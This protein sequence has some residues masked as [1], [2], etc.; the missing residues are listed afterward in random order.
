MNLTDEQLKQV[1]EYASYFFSP[2]EI[3]IILGIDHKTTL[4]IEGSEF[5]NA[6]QKGSLLSQ[7]KVRKSI[8]DLA[9]KGSS[10]AQALA[11]QMMDKIKINNVKI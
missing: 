10:P 6:Y 2:K 8:I 5:S 4:T 3:C 11:V 1:E 9:Q 7:A